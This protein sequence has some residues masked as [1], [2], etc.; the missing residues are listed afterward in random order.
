[1][2]D[3]PPFPCPCCGYLVFDEQPGAYEICPVCGWED[4]VSQLRFPTTGGANAPLIECQHEYA[5]PPVWE[6]P[7]TNPEQFGYVRDLDWR[8]LDPATD[9]M[10]QPRKGVD[11]GGTYAA[12]LTTYYYWRNPVQTDSPAG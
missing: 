10:Q 11:Y 4:D 2:S 12:D 6:R 9:D 5:H 3:A 7:L 1:M 8:P